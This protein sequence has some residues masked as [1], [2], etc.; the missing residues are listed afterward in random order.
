VP[1]RQSVAKEKLADDPWVKM[2][3]DNLVPNARGF[4]P[5]DSGLKLREIFHNR[6][7]ELFLGASPAKPAAVAAA[8]D[9]EVRRLLRC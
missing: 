9:A 4:P 1:V 7:Q 5:D 8:I 6:Y 3:L 2:T